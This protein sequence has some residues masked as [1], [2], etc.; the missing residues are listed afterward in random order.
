MTMMHRREIPDFIRELVVAG[1]EPWAGSS[2]GWHIGDAH[3]GDD[4]RREIYDICARYGDCDH[5][6]RDIATYLIWI[7]RFSPYKRDD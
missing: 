3:V 6:S 1:A 5:L 7:S 2:A 4:A